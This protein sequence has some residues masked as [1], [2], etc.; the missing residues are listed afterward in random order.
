[1]ATQKH[2]ASSAPKTGQSA[3]LGTEQVKSDSPKPVHKRFQLPEEVLSGMAQIRDDL[4]RI[5][6]HQMM[7]IDQ[8]EV[9]NHYV[10][11]KFDELYQ[12][13]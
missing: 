12:D 5:E 8:L 7:F 10:Y 3:G 11:L 9:P 4:Y 6:D 1:M 2:P 13:L